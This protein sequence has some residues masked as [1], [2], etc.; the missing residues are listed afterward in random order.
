M[1]LVQINDR[2]WINPEHVIALAYNA[3]TFKTMVVCKDKVMVESD[4]TKLETM[5]L[6]T[7]NH[8]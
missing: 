4:H 1:R 8:G 7:A 2:T 3:E 5:A 6:L